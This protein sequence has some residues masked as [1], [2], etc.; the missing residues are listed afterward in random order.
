ME[1]S[2]GPWTKG[3]FFIC[4]KCG[5]RDDGTGIGKDFAEDLKKEFKGR[6]RDDG[7]GREIR[8]MTSSCL[9]LCPPEACVAGW[10]PA[11]G[12]GISLIEFD[13]KEEKETL[14]S[15]LKKR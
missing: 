11:S 13:P 6:L 15:W 10:S 12:E 5:R 7:L 3:A 9:S 8:V 4:E 2:P 14:Y 1:I